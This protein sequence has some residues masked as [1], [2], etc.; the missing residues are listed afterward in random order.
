MLK[1]NVNDTIAAIATGIGECGIGI[2]RISGKDAVAIS[3]NIFLSKE[4]KPISGFKTHTVHYGFI[5]NG[6]PVAGRRSPDEKNII[7]EVLLTV[8]RAP[9]T[10]TREDV[11]EISCHGGIVAMRSVLDLVLQNGA[12]L[13]E[14]GEFTKRAF[15]NGRIDLTQAEAVLDI[16]KAKTDS[17]LNLGINQLQGII[18]KELEL[19]RERV[20]NSL[21]FLEA[22]I[23]FPEEDIEEA[24]LEELRETLQHI[25]SKLKQILDSSSWA[26]VMREGINVVIC[27]KPNV[28]KS[29]LLNALLKEE[30]SIVTP[31]AGTTRD[32]IEEIIDIRGIPVK[33]VD[34]AGILEPRDLIEKKAVKRSKEQIKKADLIILLFDGSSKIDSQD[35]VVIKNVVN[36][37]VIVVINKIDLKQRIE[38]GKIK[39]Q[40]KHIIHLCA[41]KT[42]NIN[43]LEEKVFELFSKG[44]INVNE[45]CMVSNLRHIHILRKAQKHIVE[46]I[47]SLDNKMSLEFVTQDI[48][49]ALNEL[50]ELLGRNFSVDLLE[51]I[52]SE[53]CIGK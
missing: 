44:S 16:I 24:D 19:L 43:L 31:V 13:A 20:L 46:S 52:F 41:K 14:P 18:S 42:K 8:M 1:G 4:R 28:G 17:A 34:T 33:I 36:K 51:K 26:R 45:P 12:R 9:K 35:E 29:S 48:K 39:K 47:N 25:N 2:V 5:I 40:F 11:V 7:D 50:D 3:E 37:H 22:N 6:S 27:G 23:D 49:Y 32:T 10:Y 53:F 38:E 30:R 21:T 15:L